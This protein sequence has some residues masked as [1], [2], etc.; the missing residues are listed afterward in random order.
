MRQKEPLDPDIPAP[1]F[2]CYPKDILSD[3]RYKKLTNAERGCFCELWLNAWPESGI[4]SDITEL[5]EMCRETP[6]EMAKLWKKVSK[7]FAPHPTD[8]EKLVFPAHEKQR[9]EQSAFRAKQIASG[10]KGGQATRRRWEETNMEEGRPSEPR[11]G[12]P[13]QHHSS[14]SSSTSSSSSS[15]SPDPSKGNGERER[16]QEPESRKLLRG[17]VAQIM[18]RPAAEKW[19]KAEL[20]ALDAIGAITEQ[21]ISLLRRFYAANIPEPKDRRRRTLL[22][23]LQTW[24]GEL[25]KARAHF[26]A[27]NNAKTKPYENNTKNPRTDRQAHSTR[28]TPQGRN[29]HRHES[30]RRRQPAPRSGIHSP[31][32]IPSRKSRRAK[33]DH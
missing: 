30:Y 1:T 24:S 17:Q 15:L 29:G 5:A 8:P 19:S 9:A 28:R 2:Q 26:K 33:K 11:A 22:T 32:Q 13:Q 25:D 18:D 7:L 10:S 23:L 14:S 4:P 27:H 6:E 31:K 20:D 16:I 21:E 3:F 12:R